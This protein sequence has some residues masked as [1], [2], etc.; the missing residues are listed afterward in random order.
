MKLIAIG[1]FVILAIGL[2]AAAGKYN[3]CHQDCCDR[4]F[5]NYNTMQDTCDINLDT[6]V[7]SIK[8]NYTACM[9]SCDKPVPTLYDEVEDVVAN[10]TPTDIVAEKENTTIV[11]KTNTT[12]ASGTQANT[13]STGTSGSA[14]LCAA[15]A[16]AFLVILG[17]LARK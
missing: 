1:V 12:T 17:F 13:T 11:T 3:A 10:I 8:G 7:P 6:V 5:S 9:E 2:A 14:P 16:L 4:S 15:P